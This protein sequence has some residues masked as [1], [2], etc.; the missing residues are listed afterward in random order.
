MILYTFY[1][2]YSNGKTCKTLV[3]YQNQDIDI[4]ATHKS[5]SAFPS[6][7]YI[8]LVCVCIYSSV[9]FYHMCRVVYPVPQPRHRLVSSL[10]VFFLFPFDNYTPLTSIHFPSPQTLALHNH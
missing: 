3:Q 8:H 2:V 4:D 1:P 5:Y 10:E 7:T 6:F 9:E